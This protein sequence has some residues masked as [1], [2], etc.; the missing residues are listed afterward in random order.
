M[1]NNFKL[2]DNTFNKLREILSSESVLKLFDHNH[3]TELYTYASIY[4]R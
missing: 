4:L 1:I 3:Q 2:E